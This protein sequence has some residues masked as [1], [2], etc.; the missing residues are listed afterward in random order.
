MT[1]SSP[2]NSRVAHN[3][4]AN[5]R[6]R[7]AGWVWISFSLSGAVAVALFFVPAFVIRPFRYQSPRALW[8]AMALRQHAPTATLIATLVC[9]AFASLL[10]GNTRRWGRAVVSIVAI[11]VAFAAAMARVNY[12]EWMF[13]P[14]ASAQFRAQSDSKLDPA[15]MIMSVRFGDEARAYPIS[16]MAYH[17]ILNDVV[18][19]VPIAVTY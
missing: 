18:G 15:E 5:E 11:V 7:R 1:A 4:K 12:F 10:W 9:L 16:Q 2:L 17:H 8:L 19:G 13:H 3:A 14:I 6:Q